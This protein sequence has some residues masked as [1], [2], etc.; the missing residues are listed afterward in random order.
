MTNEEQTLKVQG[1]F[2]SYIRDVSDMD[3]HESKWM[4]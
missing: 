1:N 2:V 4:N 3:T